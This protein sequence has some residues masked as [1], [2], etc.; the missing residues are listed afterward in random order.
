MLKPLLFDGEGF[1]MLK[2]ALLL[3]GDGFGMLNVWFV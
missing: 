3:D 1:G 2:L